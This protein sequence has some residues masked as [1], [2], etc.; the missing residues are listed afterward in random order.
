MQSLARFSLANRALIA[1]VTIFVLAFGLLSTG[2]LKQE[3]IP[4]LQ[5]PVAAVITTYVGA[6][7]AVV[8]EQ[9]SR[10][11]SDAVKGVAGLEKVTSTASSGTSVVTVQVKYGTDLDKVQSQLQTAVNR[12]Q[13]TFP[14]G[15]D[16]QVIA[17]SFDDFPIIQL[18]VSSDLSSED[19]APKLNDSAVTTLSRLDGVR[20]V[21]VS[22]APTRRVVVDLDATK[23]AA[24]G[25]TSSDVGTALRVNGVRQ[26]G[27]AVQDGTDTLSIEVGAPFA[28]LQQIKDVPLP[29]ATPATGTT[30][31]TGT[32]PT[33]AKLSDVAD[34]AERSAPPTGYSR[35][36]GKPA[37]TL[38][39]TKK[40]DGNTVAVSDE[41]RAALPDLAGKIGGNA[42][43]TVAFDQAPFISQSISDLTT[44]GL[45]GLAMAIVVIL[46]FLM[47]LRSTL[48]TAVSIPM[49]LMVTMIVL[50]GLGYSLN[51]L[52][53]GALTIA[54][55]RVV[56]D[57]IVVIENIKRHLSYG[58]EKLSAI[59]T[60]VREVAGAVTASTA[61]TVAVFA[62]I[63]FVGGQV[64]ELF[65]PFAVTVAVALLA[66][67][68]VALT[69]IPVLAYWW[70][71]LRRSQRAALDASPHS[72]VE[73]AEAKERRSLLQRG[74]LPV[75][76][77]AIAH[78]VITLVIAVVIL[79]GTVALTPQLTT[80]FLGDSGQNTI[81]VSQSL[82][83]GTSLETTDAAA[84]KVES[85]ISAVDGI[86]TVQTTVGSSG[87]AGAAFLGGTGTN[88]ATF[89]VTFDEDADATVVQDAVTAAVAALTDVGETTVSAAASGFGGS[90]IDVSL[91]APDEA[92]LAAATKQVHTAVAD[93]PGTSGTTDN[94]ASDQ[95]ILQ[96][97]VDRT[98]AVAAGTTEAAIGQ[99]VSAL[100]SPARTATL[101]SGGQSTDVVLQLRGVP[102]GIGAIADLAIPT[103]TGVKKLSD[104]ADVR[105]VDVPTTVTRENSERNSTVS[106]TP[107]GKDLG[108]VTSDL[109]KRIDALDLPAGVV[110]TIG[111]VSEDQQ[112][113]FRQLFLALLAAIAIVYVVMVATFK[114]L[115]QP[116]LLL[117][118]VPFAATGALIALL[119][120]DTPLGV[121]SL[122]GMLMLVGIVVTNAI[123]LIDLV[124]Q[125][126][127]DGMSIEEAVF[128]GARLRL[129]PILMTAIATI[130][131]L[132]PMSL[133]LTGGGAFISQPLAVVVIGGLF[134]ST[135]LTLV[136][137]PVLYTLI[138][139][140]RG[141]RSRRH[142]GR[143][144]AGQHAAA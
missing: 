134:S 78:P 50:R 120:S 61:T 45:L 63:A 39:V 36:D 136:L 42:A 144:R 16:S 133:G 23:L 94:L 69:I 130:F 95:P 29:P 32:K 38:G 86:T 85:A 140:A 51:I 135:V 13:G 89:A 19:L 129:R 81:T 10:P 110:T 56:D 83:D 3:L 117:V 142:D 41:V 116:L 119:I 46:I 65:R 97:Q 28:R 138:E 111:G 112:D 2:A 113:S 24:R 21:T 90:T 9:I 55:G 64:G 99:Q 27:G 73:I 60:A 76:R 96:V 74:Y 104:L 37:L 118:S 103:P 47:S 26:S 33:V 12:I 54:I 53:L 40:P 115:I 98:K 107:K 106:T 62:P 79:G 128:D 14:D 4:S 80:N 70:L 7:P 57:S 35:V 71:G 68:F 84:K 15:V 43:F 141:W 11:I 125:R 8:D 137:V 114:S 77:R 131:A 30:P 17:G 82:P 123:V 75:L 126:R 91:T 48:V 20:D 58:E 93:T 100:V 25:L 88:Q 66:S 72:A 52:T 49:S 5:L 124:N 67:L 31:S 143:P 22:G 105:R 139:R 6:S 109:T 18:A 44:E 108:T 127:R 102:A 122:I 92:S 101:T 132:I 1:L 59:L 34:V 87:D 121:P